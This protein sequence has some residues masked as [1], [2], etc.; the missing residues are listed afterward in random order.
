[1]VL[2]PNFENMA[3]LRTLNL[4]HCGIS[5]FPTGLLNRP[6]LANAN[7]SHNNLRRLPE[8]LYSLPASAAKAYDLSGNP[9]TR[10]TLE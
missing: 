10:A 6:R 5:I 4:S 7:L 9:L 3:N 2:A 8:A 1:L